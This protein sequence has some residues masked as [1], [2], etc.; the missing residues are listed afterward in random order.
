MDKAKPYKMIEDESC[1]MASEPAV[2]YHA[3]YQRKTMPCIYTD[4]EFVQVLA[5]AEA[6][7]YIEHE[8]ALKE[9]QNCLSLYRY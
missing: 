2:A 7:G 5:E 3:N 1:M 6:S 4:E 9:I 8:E